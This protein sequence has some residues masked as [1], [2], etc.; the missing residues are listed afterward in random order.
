MAGI[1]KP[2]ADAPISLANGMVG[3][4]WRTWFQDI[5]RFFGG[6]PLPCA[7]FTV[8]DAPDAALHSGNIIYIT[9]EAGGAVPAFSDGINWRRVTDRNIIS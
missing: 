3:R 6:Q 2:P 1:K 8:S 9:D 4:G 5:S 7:A